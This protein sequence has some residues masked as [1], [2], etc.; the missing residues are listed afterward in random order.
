MK[1]D[2]VLK[3]AY[4]KVLNEDDVPE[5]KSLKG[6]PRDIGGSIAGLNEK[7]NELFKNDEIDLKMAIELIKQF[8]PKIK[9][10]S[11]IMHQYNVFASKKN[12]NDVLKIVKNLFDQLPEDKYNVKITDTYNPHYSN[13]AKIFGIL[14]KDVWGYDHSTI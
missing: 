10:S 3:E 1:F 12:L 2:K 4:S 13:I 9:N 5:I 14:T 11:D 6:A 7:F 8:N